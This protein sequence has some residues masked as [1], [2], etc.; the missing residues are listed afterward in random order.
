FAFTHSWRC[1]SSTCSFFRCSSYALPFMVYALPSALLTDPARPARVD[2]MSCARSRSTLVFN[3]VPPQAAYR[4]QYDVYLPL[5]VQDKE[6]RR[7]RLHQPLHLLDE[8]VADAS[9]GG[10]GGASPR[11]MAPIVAPVSVAPSTRPA[12]KPAAAQPRTFDAAN[13]CRS[14]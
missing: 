5:A 14:S 13:G 4:V 10:G 12:R 2:W 8:G 9:C 6:G 7:P 3:T 11:T 1:T